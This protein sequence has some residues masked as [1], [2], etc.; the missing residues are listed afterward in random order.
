[1]HQAER[2][3]RTRARLLEAGL[4]VFALAGYRDASIDDVA[5]A[6]GVS[7]GAFYFHFTSKEDL[8][9]E[10]LRRWAARRTREL[11]LA[12]E[13]AAGGPA[14]RV[15]AM[16]AALFAYDD[17]RWPRLL[18]E[19]WSEATRSDDVATALA[20]I[21]RHWS[22]MLAIAIAPAY[23]APGSAEAAAIAILAMHDGLVCEMALGRT[24]RDGELRERVVTPLIAFLLASRAAAGSDIA[25]RGS[26]RATAPVRR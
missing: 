1:M 4:D 2:R 16:L 8:L 26:E 14:E 18:V 5:H 7:K 17:F 11:R 20:R 19:F 9:A 21:H 15:G 3:A 12:L 25:A 22:R 23:P 13:G 10:L 24:L 6:A